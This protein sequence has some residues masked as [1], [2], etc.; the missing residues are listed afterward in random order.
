M[1]GG[2]NILLQT[3]GCEQKREYFHVYVHGE[4]EPMV[5]FPIKDEKN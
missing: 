5:V 4:V 2:K 3:H 1:R